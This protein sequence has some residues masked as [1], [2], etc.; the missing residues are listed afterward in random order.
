METP[1]PG[2]TPVGRVV[3]KALEACSNPAEVIRQAREGFLEKVAVRNAERVARRRIPRLRPW[4]LV[5]VGFAT[6]AVATGILFGSSRPI[7]FHV[8]TSASTGRNG[9]LI[10]APTFGAVPVHFSEG[11]YFVLQGGGRARVLAT[12]GRG[13]RVLVDSGD[14]DVTIAHPSRR[15]GRWNFEAGPFHVLVTGTKFH[16]AWNPTIQRFSLATT[17]GR[18][19]VT[20][21]CMP[22]AKAIA[23][24]DHAELSCAPDVA[25]P[26]APPAETKPSAGP[27]EMP[28]AVAPTES[29]PAKAMP[30]P[31]PWR[32]RIAAGRIRDGLHAAEVAGFGR[33]CQEA[34]LK[35]LIALADA[36][37][38]SGRS[39]RATEALRAL[40]QRYPHTMEASTA[41]FT[42]GRIAFEQRSAYA[43][44]A[45]WFR[46]YLSEQPSGP[47]MGDSVG[48]LMEARQ[49]GGD[50][51]GARQDA[52]RYLRR[53]PEGP[54]ASEARAILQ[55]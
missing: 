38:L 9:D 24:G 29:S 44:A 25:S 19:V 55:K 17:E 41:A 53:F 10:E 23:A 52:E 6:V 3:E 33:V 13:A 21:T 32:E 31:S 46:V 12:E 15:P 7:T 5:L 16:L 54:Y 26:T 39:T 22:T 49:R 28:A 36:A 43:E 51:S 4:R 47:L 18:V 14:M 50:M 30:K 45:T 37:R 34:S 42:L 2:L 8:G 35:E 48:R 20:S 27:P 40:R 1:T 11:S